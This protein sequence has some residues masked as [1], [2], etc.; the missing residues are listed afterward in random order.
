MWVHTRGV[1]ALVLALSVLTAACGHRKPPISRRVVLSPS[2][3][4]SSEPTTRPAAT[5]SA[6]SR[7]AGI[8]GVQITP[9]PSP[10]PQHDLA[11]ARI[12]LTRLV[13]LDQPVAMAVRKDD[14]SFYIAEK[15]GTIRTYRDGHVGGDVL[16]ISSE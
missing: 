1:A 6:P 14:P 9:S 2:A 13:T 7:G 16:D 15:G 3:T 11:H 8:V 12:K 10:T 4:A 5:T